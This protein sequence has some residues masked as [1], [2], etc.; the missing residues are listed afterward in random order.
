[1]KKEDIKQYF[2]TILQKEKDVS[3]GIAAIRTLMEIL[4]K[5]SYKTIQGLDENLK[6]GVEAMQ[7][8][9]CPVA[10][11]NS[12][13][14]L[15]RR[16]ITFTK[17]DTETFDECKEIM[18]NRGHLFI[19]NLNE[20]KGKIAK[21]A[22]QFIV[23]GSKVLTHSRSRVVLQTL[24]EAAKQN[25]QFEVFVTKSAP[26]NSG[27]K[28]CKDLKAANIPH[29]LILDSAVGYIME[30]VDFVIVGAEAVVESGGVINKIGTYTMALC[31]KEMNRPFYVLTESFKFSRLFPLN[32]ADLPDTYKYTPDMRK[33]DISKL[34]PLVDYTPPALI[35]LLF[36]DLGILTPSA[37]SDELIKLY[38]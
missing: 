4:R 33:Q 21:R 29:T 26:D 37:V 18:L 15:F 8:T 36:T 35:T 38:L 1:M 10:A 32:Q 27:E 3:A 20:A 12:G 9:N 13:C 11:I 6:M 17:L 5:Y 23:D 25:K 22:S 31:A 30:Q 16:F 2:L 24:K 7:E 28:M 14:E 34:N 19:K